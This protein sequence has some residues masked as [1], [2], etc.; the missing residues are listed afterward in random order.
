M[1]ALHRTTDAPPLA[2]LR[3][4]GKTILFPWAEL[5]AL[6]DLVASVPASA[7]DDEDYPRV[8]RGP[9]AAS[10]SSFGI[11]LMREGIETL[12]LESDEWKS[13]AEILYVGDDLL[14]QVQVAALTD[15][16]QQRVAEAISMG[17][18]FAFQI[19]GFQRRQWVIPRRAAEEWDAEYRSEE[20]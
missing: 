18:L 14:S 2:V 13:L 1:V 15:R 9:W 17:R 8:E 20:R 12:F 6:R 3:R 19:P 7:A 10:G 11:A 4:G 16:R 5:L